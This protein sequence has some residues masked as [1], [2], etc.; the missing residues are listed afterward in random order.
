MLCVFVCSCLSFYFS[1]SF[2][3]SRSLSFCWRPVVLCGPE[4]AAHWSVLHG[5]PP[6]AGQILSKYRVCLRAGATVHVSAVFSRQ[7]KTHERHSHALLYW[8]CFCRLSLFAE[9]N[10]FPSVFLF[11]SFPF[12]PPLQSV[13]LPLGSLV[14]WPAP[15]WASRPLTLAWSL[16]SFSKPRPQVRL[17]SFSLQCSCKSAI[18]TPKTNTRVSGV[19][20]KPGEVQASV[21]TLCDITIRTLI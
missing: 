21:S 10:F 15:P 1:L 18:I 12:L 19:I 6:P 11:F 7:R 2:S 20:T 9:I 3:L 8:K 4:K 16:T 17:L 5:G 14:P 13:S